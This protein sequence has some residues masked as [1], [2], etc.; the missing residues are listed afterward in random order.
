MSRSLC[1]AWRGRGKRGVEST[2]RVD[3]GQIES[4]RWED[5]GRAS[6]NP[7]CANC[8]VH[9]GY[10]PTAVDFTFSGFRGIWAN[11]KAMLFNR[12][13]SPEAA[14]RLDEEKTRPHGPMQHLVQLGF[15]MD[16]QSDGSRKVVR[17]SENAA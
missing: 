14:K 9:C 13:A 5:Y 8:M 16:V 11:I 6:G 2:A 4:T 3:R 15:A 12:Y 7:K 10:E 1:S 17:K